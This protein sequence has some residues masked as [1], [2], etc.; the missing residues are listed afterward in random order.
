M[1]NKKQTLILPNKPLEKEIESANLN[2]EIKEA[3]SIYKDA[4]LAKQKELETKLATLEIMPVGNRII[5]LPYPHNPYKQQI[6]EGG[7]L[8]DYEGQFLNPDT[9]TQSK[10]QPVTTCGKV[11]EAG[12]DC[13]YV[14]NGDDVFFP[15]Q[16]TLPLPFFN[17]GYLQT[18][19]PQILAVINEGLTKRFEELKK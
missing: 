3:N 7:I 13:L 11:I 18:S 12:P 14:K 15:T 10:L 5:V 4:A 1:L 6:T 9:G 2:K 8:I 19:E 17:M 16:S